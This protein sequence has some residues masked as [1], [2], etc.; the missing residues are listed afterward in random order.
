MTAVAGPG[1]LL[2]TGV[3]GFVGATVVEL[4][5]SA[6][7]SVVG[8]SRS[9]NVGPRIAHL[10]DEHHVADLSDERLDLGKVDGVIHLAGLAAVAP[11]FDDPAGYL[12][13]NGA[14]MANLAE[15]VL[16]ESRDA[17]FVVVSSGAVYGPSEDG[18]PLTESS[19]VQFPSPYA[20]SKVLVENLASYYR[21][22]GLDAVV[23]R[24]FNHIGPGQRLGAIV[25]D[26]V[27]RLRDHQDGAEFAGG[28][29][30][31]ARDYLDVR[32]VARAYEL[33][34][35]TPELG[36]TTFN[37][38]SGVSRTGHEVLAAVCAAMGKPVPRATSH[39]TRAVDPSFV[40]G[41]AERLRK[42]TG[43]A[44]S[45]PFETSIADYVRSA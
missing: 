24:P 26:L 43:W 37:V 30:G 18:T 3:S 29:L 32:D 44:P 7:H 41:E 16:D 39:E 9:A 25:P 42:T 12:R 2:V 14:I 31:S 21:A 45:V 11:S 27:A 22:R 19:Q 38:A 4:L 15:S 10:L 5:A 34:L 40:R 20:V 1:R 33:L 8:T 28:N 13:V 36:E 6:G 23:A 35:T 17:R